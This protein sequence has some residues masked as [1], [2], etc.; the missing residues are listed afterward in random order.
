MSS[1]LSCCPL[2]SQSIPL[3]K[4]PGMRL[5]F[6][7][8]LIHTPLGNRRRATPEIAVVNLPPRSAGW[9]RSP[10]R[11]ISAGLKVSKSLPRPSTVTIDSSFCGSGGG[12]QV[13]DP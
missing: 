13:Q 1:T 11:M 6:S 9:R 5:T 4:K 2:K 12:Q 3:G 7:H 8:M 10:R